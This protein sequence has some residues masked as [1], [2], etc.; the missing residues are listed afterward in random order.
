[1]EGEKDNVPN[2]L[3]LSGV[4][5]SGRAVRQVCVRCVV[6]KIAGGG[7]EMTV[8]SRAVIRLTITVVLLEKDVA[9]TILAEWGGQGDG[10]KACG[11]GRT[12]RLWRPSTMGRAVWALPSTN[13]SAGS[14]GEPGGWVVTS[15]REEIAGRLP[16]E[17]GDLKN[18]TGARARLAER[19]AMWSLQADLLA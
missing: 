2:E 16:E 15:V 10:N 14:P 11:S 7:R 1:M 12:R 5:F 6:L 4:Q 17:W 3:H 8:Q 19:I 9:I 13:S 18:T